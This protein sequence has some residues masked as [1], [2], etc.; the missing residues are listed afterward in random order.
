VN[1]HEN[2]TATFTFNFTPLAF[3]LREYSVTRSNWRFDVVARIALFL[4][5]TAILLQ[6]LPVLLKPVL[7]MTL[8]LQS[9]PQQYRITH[10]SSNYIGDVEDGKE[11]GGGLMNYDSGAW[12]NGSW[13]RGERHGLGKF[14]S[15]DGNWYNGSWKDGKVHG[16][17]EYHWADGTFYSG[18]FNNNKFHG[19]GVR[20]WTDGRKYAG[21][22]E[23]HEMHG[24][25]ILTSASGETRR[26]HWVKASRF[27]VRLIV[28]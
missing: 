18:G 14:H 1:D 15:A 12:Y 2:P 27:R 21:A 5:C 16:H 22:W 13:K 7:A 11:H 20:T 9:R 17:G 26:G 24:D 23:N 3:T 4:V 28:V 6:R 19:N 10:E 8:L 25:G